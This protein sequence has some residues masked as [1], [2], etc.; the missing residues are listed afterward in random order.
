MIL[1]SYPPISLKIGI[2]ASLS[3]VQNC[4]LKH[5]STSFIISLLLHYQTQVQKEL[6]WPCDSAGHCCCYVACVVMATP[7]L[8]HIDNSLWQDSYVSPHLMSTYRHRASFLNAL[9]DVCLNTFCQCNPTRKRSRTLFPEEKF[10]LLC[11][12]TILDSSLFK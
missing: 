8:L 3:L 10:A 12:R 9:P 1:T 5:Q 2:L 7:Q 11:R 4:L 6:I